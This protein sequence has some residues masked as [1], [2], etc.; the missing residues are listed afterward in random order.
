MVEEVQDALYTGMAER[1]GLS[2]E[3]FRRHWS[4]DYSARATGARRF[5]ESHQEL[6]WRLGLTVTPAVIQEVVDLQVEELGRCLAS[7]KPGVPETLSALDQAGMP[8]A[9]LSNAAWEVVELWPLFPLGDCFT[10]RVFSCEVGLKKPD[11]EIFH[12]VCE[13][14]GVQPAQCLYVG[15]GRDQELAGAASV[16]MTPVQ[17]RTARGVLPETRYVIGDFTELLPILGVANI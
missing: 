2:E 16:G 12:L 6:W 5:R 9:L 15:D 7:I 8:R 4:R 1:L 10:T 14:A 3:T 11:P 13:R 17:V